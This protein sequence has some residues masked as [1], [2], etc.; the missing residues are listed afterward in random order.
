MAGRWKIIGRE[1]W[2]LEFDLL[3]VQIT[4]SGRYGRTIENQYLIR[5]EEKRIP[6]ELLKERKYS[7]RT[8]DGKKWVEGKLKRVAKR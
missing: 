2:N 4:Y 8:L 7:T 6:K 3:T 1:Y 5:K